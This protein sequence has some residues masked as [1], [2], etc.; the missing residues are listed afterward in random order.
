MP[1]PTMPDLLPFGLEPLDS[2]LPCPRAYTSGSTRS[3]PSC[4]GYGLCG[5]AV[6]AGSIATSNPSAC[7]LSRPL[8][9]PQR[10]TSATATRRAGSAVE[11]GRTYGVLCR[12]AR[13]AD[14]HYGIRQPVLTYAPISRRGK[15]TVAV[16]TRLPALDDC[17]ECRHR[18]TAFE[19]VGV[20]RGYGP[21]HPVQPLTMRL[22]QDAHVPRSAEA[23][24]LRS[25]APG[26]TVCD[27]HVGR[28]GYPA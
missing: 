3:M 7:N 1:S 14:S 27:H 6:V 19:L 21:P 22:A 4:A 15:A 16:R 11:G 13:R 26:D 2:R 9:T 24:S 12:S 8:S 10:S 28:V 25:S 18:S 17:L 23:T 20:E 5:A